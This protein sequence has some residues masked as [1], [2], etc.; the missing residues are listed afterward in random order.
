VIASFSP[1]S[2]AIG[3]PGA[4]F[5]KQLSVRENLLER[6]EC[7]DAKFTT[8]SFGLKHLNPQTRT[9]SGAVQRIGCASETMEQA[10]AIL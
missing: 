1:S 7:K 3:A 6:Q 4:S 9:I 5:L 2:E 8:A 10:P